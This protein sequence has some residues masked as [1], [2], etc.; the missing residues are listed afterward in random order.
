MSK[1]QWSIISVA[2]MGIALVV[3]LFISDEAARIVW[4]IVNLFFN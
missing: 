3:S 4:N 2:I 1:T